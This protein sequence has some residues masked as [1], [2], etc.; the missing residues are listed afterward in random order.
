MHTN[1]EILG[2]H[3][4]ADITKDINESNLLLDSLLITSSEGGGSEGTS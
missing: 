3:Q 1:P 4:N 2:F